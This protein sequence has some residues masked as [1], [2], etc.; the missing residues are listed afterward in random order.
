MGRRARRTAGGWRFRRARAAAVRRLS[1]RGRG[2]SVGAAIHSLALLGSECAG[3]TIF[4][5][6]TGHLAWSCVTASACRLPRTLDRFARG[7]QRAHIAHV[8]RDSAATFAGTATA[9][10]ASAG[11][12]TARSGPTLGHLRTPGIASV[13]DGSLMLVAGIHVRDALVL[14]LAGRLRRDDH[15]HTADT[16][17]G[18]VAAHQP[19]V[20]LT[21][22]ERMA[23]LDVLLDPPPGLEELRGVLLAEHLGRKREGLA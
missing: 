12:D 17:E 2:S 16:L 6:P 22:P 19:S 8:G 20:A 9:R 11:S 10:P 3:N 18:A 23:I 1:F 21:I 4:R 15:A 14:E 13:H 5:Y 7:S